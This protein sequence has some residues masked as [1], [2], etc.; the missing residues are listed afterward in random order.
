MR[1]VSGDRSC[2]Q[3]IN[4]QVPPLTGFFSGGNML[5]TVPEAHTSLLLVHN[6]FGDIWPE[7]PNYPPWESAGN[8][9][10]GFYEWASLGLRPSSAQSPSSPRGVLALATW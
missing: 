9:G 4:S 7:V 8:S 2:G 3:R 10:V 5:E 6:L 1:E